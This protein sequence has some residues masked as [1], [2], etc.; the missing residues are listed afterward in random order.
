MAIP[1]VL[2][3]GCLDGGGSKGYDVLGLL[4]DCCDLDILENQAPFCCLFSTLLLVE[5]EIL[6]SRK[7]IGELNEKSPLEFLYLV[8]FLCT[9]DTYLGL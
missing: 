2:M 3:F 5:A 9:L 1:N 4:T 6:V 7:M 8:P